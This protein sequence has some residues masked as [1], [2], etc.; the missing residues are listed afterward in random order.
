MELRWWIDHMTS[1][2]GKG[3]ISL[4][5]DMVLMSDASKRG[6]GATWG[7]HDPGVMESSGEIPAHRCTGADGSQLG[8]VFFK[9]RS[10]VHIH[11]MVDN[12]TTVAQVN[13]MGGTKSLTFFTIVKELWDNC[14]SHQI[15]EVCNRMADEESRVYNDYSNRRLDQEIINQISKV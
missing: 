5:P 6:W 1:W 8:E 12:T 15:T 11:L 2:N 9:N 4:G 10:N 3:M 7:A 14:L 13:R